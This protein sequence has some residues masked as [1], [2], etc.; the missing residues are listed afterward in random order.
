MPEEEAN[1]RKQEWLGHEERLLCPLHRTAA[2]AYVCD[3]DYDT[4]RVQ[5]HMGLLARNLYQH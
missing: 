1:Q 4:T 2:V 5:T 3:L